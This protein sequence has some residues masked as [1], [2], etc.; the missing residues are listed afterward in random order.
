MQMWIYTRELWA[1]PHIIGAP[2]LRVLVSVD[3]YNMTAACKAAERY[4][5][6][7]AVLAYNPE[8]AA[9]LWLEISKAHPKIA[10]PITCPAT[11]KYKH[12]NEGPAHIV[13]PDGKRSTLKP[14]NPAIGAC[15]ACQA[16]LPHRPNRSITFHMHNPGNR[17][18]AAI[19]TRKRL[20]LTPT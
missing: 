19:N 10:R 6:P 4:D 17:L 3:Q 18:P 14:G 20:T 1:L 7:V 9:A 16:C 12:D 2:N 15:T 13:G 11:G 5:L 8:H